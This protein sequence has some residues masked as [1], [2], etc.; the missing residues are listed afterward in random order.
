MGIDAKREQ[1][2]SEGATSSIPSSFLNLRS[3]IALSFG[4]FF[5]VLL[6]LV[7]LVW[8]FGIPFTTYSGSY[9]RE[10]SE[11]LKELSLIADLKKDRLLLWLEE[12][13][14]DAE[15]LAQD[16][17]VVTLLEHYGK[18][19]YAEHGLTRPWREVSSSVIGGKSFKTVER[20]LDVVVKAYKVYQKIQVADSREGV[21]IASTDKGDLG[22]RVGHTRFF[23]SALA[24]SRG[25]AV[26]IE[27][28]PTTRG[29]YLV[30][31]RTV[32]RPSR[33]PDTGEHPLG[34]V[35]MYINADSF[36]K[37]LL[38][39]GG[40]LGASG[41]IVLVNQDLRILISLK[42]PLRDKTRAKVLE[43]RITAEPAMLAAGG[44]EG[45]VVSRDYRGEPV[46]AAYRHIRVAPG[47]A[48]GM[49]VKRDRA[50]VFGPLKTRLIHL[51][52]M[53]LLGVLGVIV[54]A[55]L[56][57]NRI[58]KPIRLLSGIAR[59]VEAGNLGK[60]CPITSSD[61]VGTLA[62][63]FNSM[64]ERIQNWHEELESEVN[65]RTTEL[66]QLNEELEAK[67]AELERFTYTVSHDLK[68][69]LITIKGFL[70]YLRQDIAAGKQD[71]IESDLARISGAVDKMR[72]LL[73]ELLEL[74]RIGRLVNTTEQV[75]FKKLVA[76]AVETVRGRIDAR[77]I[78]VE[79]GE[80]LPVV[81]GDRSRLS[82][83]IEN[84]LSNSV[85]FMGDQPDPR[86]RVDARQ[87]DGEIVLYVAD[88]GSGIDRRYHEKIF[89]LFERLNRQVEGTGIGLAIVKRIVET[90]GGRVWV[91]SEGEGKGSTFCF[92][93]PDGTEQEKQEENDDAGR[94]ESGP[95]R[96]R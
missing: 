37:P 13:K 26:G 47:L 29:P 75:E 32:V 36:V 65:A 19:A 62:A 40:G 44:K 70:G 14:G 66:T 31:S 83:V 55:I 43:Y 93:L 71:R 25:T 7:T 94:Y 78:T 49:V 56:I 10:R 23:Q 92:T 28:S 33:K 18:T 60:R 24:L 46:L 95:A 58:S 9:G 77:G 50:E 85:K 17:A 80:D 15:V 63:T 41:D 68:N 73:D 16:E 27:K 87:D 22:V 38:Y 72:R 59:E 34:V 11:A 67:N 57:A 39:T 76:E 64:V 45:I 48:W 96:R 42:Y 74:S 21:I 4:F 82:E 12:R 91:K 88:N 84:L 52:L 86:I 1:G 5:T 51:S 69:P 61:D 3:K 2:V 30:I 54:L 53:G 89:G 81:R 35:I 20:H 79:I 90:H 8:A 6:L